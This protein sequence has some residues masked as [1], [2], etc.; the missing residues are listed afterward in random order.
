MDVSIDHP[1]YGTTLSLRRIPIF[2]FIYYFLI[3]CFGFQGLWWIL[4]DG[5]NARQGVESY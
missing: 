1:D 2:L 5:P 4:R 3:S